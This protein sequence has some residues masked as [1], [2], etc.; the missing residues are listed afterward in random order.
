MSSAFSCLFVAM[1][2]SFLSFR[3]NAAR[4]YFGNRKSQIKNP[5]SS[6][7]IGS[8]VRDVERNALP[9]LENAVAVGVVL[10]G[11]TA[12]G[13]VVFFLLLRVLHLREKGLEAL[14]A[15]LLLVLLWLLRFLL[16]LLLITGFGL[17]GKQG[18]EPSEVLLN[19]LLTLLGRLVT[20]VQLLGHLE[21][22][23]GFF[24]M[25]DGVFG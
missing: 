20:L 6:V 7:T 25:G 4:L 9:V 1:P 23:G 17:L 10:L 16:G 24:E 18:A 5:R 8:R 21:T 2:S 19:L 13:V 14:V 3:L 12:A 11:L 15:L 22:C